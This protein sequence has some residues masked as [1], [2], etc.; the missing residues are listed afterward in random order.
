MKKIIALV[1]ALVM[2]AACL[3]ACGGAKGASL[4]DVQKA[5]GASVDGIAGKETLSKTVTVSSKINNRHAVVKPI[6]KRLDALGYDCG[7]ADGIA[8]AKFTKAV[9][10]YQ[11]A[12]GCV[13]DGEITARATTWKKLLGLA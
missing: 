13:A 8:G 11:L 12:N 5:V 6:Q 2:V 1:L 3:T 4:K 10:A 7:T 9:K